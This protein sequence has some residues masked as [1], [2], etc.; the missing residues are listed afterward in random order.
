MLL[1]FYELEK[2]LYEVDYEL[3][4]RP[5]WVA[6]PLAGLARLAGVTG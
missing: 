4:N 5:P 2:V 6:V 1:E 3:N